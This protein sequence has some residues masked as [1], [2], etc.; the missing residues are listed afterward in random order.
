[1]KWNSPSLKNPKSKIDQKQLQ[2]RKVTLNLH[3]RSALPPATPSFLHRFSASFS[4]PHLNPFWA[5]FFPLPL[6]SF[7]LVIP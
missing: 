2:R 7:Y 1:M 6:A 4:S 3:S 5:P